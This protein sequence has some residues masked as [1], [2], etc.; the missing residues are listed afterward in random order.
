MSA[1]TPDGHLRFARGLAERVIDRLG[2]GAPTLVVEEVAF[3]HGFDE[4]E[5][6]MMFS[7]EPSEDVQITVAT[8]DGPRHRVGAHLVLS[9]SRAQGVAAVATHIQDYVLELTHG[10]PLP[11]CPGHSHPLDPKVHDGVACWV[12]PKDP[13]HHAEP[14]LPADGDD[15]A[16]SVRAP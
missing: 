2:P 5:W 11:P 1:R 4:H 12:C 3:Y 6:K 9:G 10:E 15:V 8:E 13:A 7:E 16:P 14:I